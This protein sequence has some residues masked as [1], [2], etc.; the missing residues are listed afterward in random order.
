LEFY[1]EDDQNAANA[2]NSTLELTIIPVNDAPI[3][4]FVSDPAV[5]ENPT[6]VLSG[7]TQMSLAYTED[8]PPLN[9]GRD[10]YL[11]DVDGNIFF[12]ILNLTSKINVVQSLRSDYLPKVSFI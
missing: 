7:A 4:L 11:R 10:I 3:L 2:M 1:V 12:A 6:P 5:Q 8:D 9:F